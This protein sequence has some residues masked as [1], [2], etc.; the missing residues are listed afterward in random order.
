MMFS[1]ILVLLQG[2]GLYAEYLGEEMGLY[3]KTALEL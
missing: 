1:L 2:W 3:N